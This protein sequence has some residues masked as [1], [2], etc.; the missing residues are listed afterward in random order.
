M[1]ELVRI[2][3]GKTVVVDEGSNH[4]LRNRLSQLRKSTARGV[5][6]R[7]GKKYPVKYEIRPK[8]G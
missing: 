1:Y 4:D 5:S 7:G 8:K 6:G 3:R 2:A